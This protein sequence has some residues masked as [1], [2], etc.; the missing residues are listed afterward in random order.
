MKALKKGF[1]LTSLTNKKASY[2][3]LLA[4][5]VEPLFWSSGGQ[6]DLRFEPIYNRFGAS[7]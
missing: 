2:F 4:L 6:E 5:F 1:K 3:C 7:D